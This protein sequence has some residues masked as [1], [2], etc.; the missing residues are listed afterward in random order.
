MKS[1]KYFLLLICAFSI[2]GCDE[3]DKRTIRKTIP[4]TKGR[5]I[6]LYYYS[7]IGGSSPDYLDLKE[8]NGDHRHLFINNLICD[9]NVYV[10]TLKIITSKNSTTSFLE[11]NNTSLKLQIDSTKYCNH[12]NITK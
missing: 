12:G 5:S 6:E 2:L 8:K 7:L 10:D 3:Y 9:A 1:I 11:T 4:L